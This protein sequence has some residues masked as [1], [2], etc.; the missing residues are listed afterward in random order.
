MKDMCNGMSTRRASAYNRWL[1]Y[2][3]CYGSLVNKKIDKVQRDSEVKERM[4]DHTS[5][6]VNLGLDITRDVSVVWK[7]GSNRRLGEEMLEG[8]N[9]AFH[10][11]VTQS[12]FYSQAPVWNQKAW[13][14]GPMIVV[15][16]IRGGHLTWDSIHP[17]ECEV[18]PDVENPYGPP[19]AVV[20]DRSSQGF[21]GIRRTDFDF[22]VIDKI[23]WRYIKKSG[24]Q[25]QQVGYEEHGFGRFPGSVLRFDVP[26]VDSWWGPD[27]HVRLVHATVTVSYLD[28]AL[29]YVRKSQRGNQLKVVGNLQGMPKGQ[30]IGDVDTALAVDTKTPGQYDIDV[31]DFDLSPDNFIKQA[32]WTMDK[33]AASYGGRTS[34]EGTAGVAF[35]RISFDHS[36]LTELRNEQIPYAR[37]FESELWPLAVEMAMQMGPLDRTADL[38][39]PERVSDELFIEYQRLSKTYSDEKEAR[40]DTDWRLSRGL[41][42]YGTVMQREHPELTEDE[43]QERI[44]AN[45]DTQFPIRE[46]QARLNASLVPDDPTKPETSPGMKDPA[47]LNG[48]KGPQVRDAHDND[49]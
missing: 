12:K 43:A 15:P 17:H 14:L 16:V 42:T 4:K 39:Q 1:I 6:A 34:F 26:T 45:L 7:P 21:F 8:E 13:F 3:E 11:L 18:L 33:I 46:K 22:I 32:S 31:L 47:E 44:E 10:Q 37:E 23:G 2:T 40:E 20:W 49:E 28:T 5:L 29:S 36:T 41:E 30:K 19:A 24:G 38:P 9:K 25:L 48:A 35:G 27:R